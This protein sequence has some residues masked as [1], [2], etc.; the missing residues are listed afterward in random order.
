[1]DPKG[2]NK[3]TER[4]KEL[5]GL[6]FE[7]DI[8]D[9]E[10]QE[11]WGYVNDPM[12][13]HEV[14]SLIPNAT[15]HPLPSYT[16]NEVKENRILGSIF[17]DDSAEVDKHRIG[18]RQLC[19]AAS[20]VV[21]L[22]CLTFALFKSQYS[23]I[24]PKDFVARDIPAGNHGATLTLAD[25]RTIH[26]TE[27]G[28]GEIARE[29]GVKIEK[30]RDGEIV[31]RMD[32]KAEK[33]NQVNTLTTSRGQTYSVLLP[34]GTKVWINA[35][36]ELRYMANLIEDGRRVVNLKGEAYFEVSKDQ[37]HPFIVRSQGQEVEVLGTHFN[38]NAY[39]NEP[40]ISTTL[41]EG[42]IR[43]HTS[44][45]QQILKP[46]QQAQNT[47]GNLQIRPAHLD[48]ITDWKEGDFSFKNVDFLAALRKIERWYNVEM[49]YDKSLPKDLQAGGWISRKKSLSSVLDFIESANMVRFKVE[50]RKVYVAP[51]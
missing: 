36:S 38:I 26:L 31:Y 13:A 7:Q 42:S 47:S 40:Y 28:N 6:Y 3:S 49:I 27:V 33:G 18:W 8:E 29:A 20:I 35:A 23:G 43:L 37:R 16:L 34:D 9:K 50:G 2:N 12:F 24:K 14:K 41:L 4:L 19:I 1:M 39:E 51:Y 15:E 22:S 10:K 48:N 17:R 11:L 25:G 44:A 45:R 5:M 46:G 21:V 30:G 32:S